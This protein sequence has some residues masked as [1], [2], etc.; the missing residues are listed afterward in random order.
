LVWPG[1][2]WLYRSDLTSANTELA[3]HADQ[4]W[5][6]TSVLRKDSSEHKLLLEVLGF[7]ADREMPSF[8]REIFRHNA[9]RAG[10]LDIWAADAERC[11][12]LVLDAELL[13]SIESFHQVTRSKPA[14]AT[15]EQKQHA[16]HLLQQ[17]LE[18]YRKIVSADLYAIALS[19]MERDKTR[20]RAL[21]E[22]VQQGNERKLA[23]AQLGSRAFRLPPAGLRAL[24]ALGTIADN[25]EALAVERLNAVDLVKMAM[26][27]GSDEDA[28]LA[29]AHLYR[30]GVLMT[31]EWEVGFDRSADRY[32]TL[33][34]MA[35]EMEGIAYLTHGRLMGQNDAVPSCLFLKSTDYALLEKVFGPSEFVFRP[36]ACV[37]D[38]GWSSQ[39]DSL[40][41][42]SHEGLPPLQG[43]ESDGPARSKAKQLAEALFDAAAAAKNWEAALLAAEYLYR[44][45][46][47]EQ[48]TIDIAHKSYL[49]HDAEL[50]A[51]WKDGLVKLTSSINGLRYISHGNVHSYLGHSQWEGR[52]GRFLKKRFGESNL[53][54]VPFEV[55]ESGALTW[56]PGA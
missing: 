27:D 50:G 21:L 2:R 36:M 47:I 29:A 42:P 18:A 13:Q 54:L 35:D 8:S 39:G 30:V 33:R 20:R 46:V 23:Q 38:G 10:T 4:E 17:H 51:T 32:P 55:V 9:L 53:R 3:E 19:R 1:R 25:R 26:R 49:L 37:L 11:F 12:L 22:S 7:L 56:P 5:D 45:R 16:Q 6:W 24:R 52:S 43:L 44:I 31:S 15:E 34:R 14:S 40:V 48:V 41:A 28:R